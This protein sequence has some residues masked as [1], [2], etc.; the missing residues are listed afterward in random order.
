MQNV[1]LQIVQSINLYLFDI[2][3]M[4]TPIYIKDKISVAIN[5]N[6]MIDP[7]NIW[8]LANKSE[9]QNIIN[10]HVSNP[11]T[12]YIFFITDCCD[13][14]SIPNNVRVYRTSLLKSLKNENEFILPYIWEGFDKFEPL[15]TT[16]KPIVGF[17][18]CS[19]PYRQQTLELF[20][21]DNRIVS[22]FIIRGSFW[23]GNPHNPK[24]IKD[25][26]DNIQNSHFNICNRGNG[27]FSMRFY[28]TLSCGRIPILLNTDTLLPFEDEINWNDIIIFANTEAELVENTVNC[29]NVVER[30]LK[31]RAVYETYFAGTKFLDRIFS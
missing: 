26:L 17:C 21:Q 11:K 14:F 5:D 23:G 24:I 3:I 13:S 16:E 10:S 28:Q 1:Q 27:N 31:C 18:G 30:Q 29:T 12:V 9:M 25:F 2:S 19:G 7:K 4:E 22:N 20:Q 15:E 6:I 8:G